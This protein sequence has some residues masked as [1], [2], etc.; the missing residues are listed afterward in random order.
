L[1]FHYRDEG[2]YSLHAFVVMPDHVHV[3]ISPAGDQSLERCMQ[4][5]KGGFSHAVR[6]QTH[7]PQEIWQRGFHEHR[8]RD[9]DYIACNPEARGIRSHA[10]VFAAGSRLDAVPE[11]LRG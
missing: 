11:H 3:L 6:M 8:V 2:R 1:I 10:F 7:R 5:I 9:M 4:C